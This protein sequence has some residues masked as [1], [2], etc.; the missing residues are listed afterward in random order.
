MLACVIAKSFIALIS[1]AC[2]NRILAFLESSDPSSTFVKPWFWICGLFLGTM[3]LSISEQTYLYY[4]TV[5]LVHTESLLTQLAFEHGLRIRLK[6]ETGSDD[7]G[8]TRVASG[9]ST[10][11]SVGGGSE[12]S[13]VVEALTSDSA[14]ANA[15]ESSTAVDSRQPSSS[16]TATVTKVKGKKDKSKKDADAEKEKE[17]KKD[18]GNL[19][20][21]INN[22]VTTDL[23]NIGQAGDFVVLRAS[24]DA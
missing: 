21:K 12:T 19:T 6:A 20:G 5:I 24:F 1:P 14:S 22:L 8:S 9:A 3:G 17:K 10:P 2:I 16:T 11:K 13:S 18:A 4:F 7:S 23:N 15:S